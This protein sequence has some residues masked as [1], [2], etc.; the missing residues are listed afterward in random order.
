M[1][2]ERD[3]VGSHTG[4]SR[5]G[6]VFC[7]LMSK[8]APKEL[9]VGAGGLMAT[10]SLAEE[11]ELAVRFETSPP[12]AVVVQCYRVSWSACL[13]SGRGDRGTASRS[14]RTNGHC[15]AGRRNR[16]GGAL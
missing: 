16:T 14:G 6:F 5:P 15:V 4:T 2:K 10:V 7:S 13:Q 8:H 9:P 1:R 11:T 12:V 3:L